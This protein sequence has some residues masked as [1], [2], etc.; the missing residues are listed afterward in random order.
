MCFRPPYSFLHE[1]SPSSS[2]RCGCGL[3]LPHDEISVNAGFLRAAPAGASRTPS[4]VHAGGQGTDSEPQKHARLLW[5]PGLLLSLKISELKRTPRGEQLQALQC[6]RR[7]AR[8]AHLR[9]RTRGSRGP[10]AASRRCAGGDPCGAWQ[11][12][13]EAHEG[14]H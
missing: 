4:G 3:H 10:S 13:G 11:A 14:F 7:C 5:F 9:V 6:A 8:G 2:R 12:S 1:S